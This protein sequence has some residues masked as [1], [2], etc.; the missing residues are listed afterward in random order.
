MKQY[1]KNSLPHDEKLF[2]FDDE[3]QRSYSELDI[4]EKDDKTAAKNLITLND[5]LKPDKQRRPVQLVLI[6]GESGIGKTTLAWQL[7]H[8]WARKELGS[9]KEYDLVVLLPLR[10]KRAQTAEK[11]EN[12]LPCD[13][14]LD[15]R[16]DIMAA[17]GRGKGVLIVCDGFDELPPKQLEE[18]SVYVDLFN[19]DLLSEAT[20][21][22]TTRPS[23]SA[24][25]KRIC[26]RR[27]DRK[28][29]IKGFTETG[30]TEFT[31][32]VFSDDLKLKGFLNYLE[33]NPTIYTLMY[34]PL[35]AII[36]AKIYQEDYETRKKTMSQLFDAFTRVLVRRHILSKHR[37]DVDR[38]TFP[39]TSPANIDKLPHAMAPHFR[40]IAKIAYDGICENMHVF[41]NPEPDKK[42]VT[43]ELMKEDKRHDLHGHYFTYVFFHYILHEYMAAIHIS[44]ML[45]GELDSLQLKLKKEDMITRFLAGICHTNRYE[46]SHKLLQWLIEFLRC[47]CFDRSGALQLVHCAYECFSIMQ[48]LK[49]PYSEKNQFI[50][51]EPKVGIDWYAMGYCIRH[52][53]ERWGLR[54]HATSLRDTDLLKKGLEC[55]LPKSVSGVPPT[56][57]SGRLKY[58]YISKSHL[59]ISQVTTSLGDFGQLHHLDVCVQLDENDKKICVFNGDL[60]ALTSF[61]RSHVTLQVLQLGQIVDYDTSTANH[62]LRELAEVV[63]NRQL[64][65]LKLHKVDYDNL[66]QHLRKSPIIIC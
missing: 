66:P 60:P 21:V 19:G 24:D 6:E 25:F 64:K 54:M 16:K 56:S 22:V 15:N 49:V 29:E 8:Q 38:I 36:I 47:N 10:K 5:I 57:V 7:C 63:V 58:L 39:L 59:P 12:L 51:V 65:K 20:V 1:H 43:L 28:V 46:H 52:F 27:V 35:S 18:D 44:T 48:E 26:N 9:V 32:S 31:K 30:I 33:N 50:V 45:S 4:I 13:K 3:K 55:P 2:Y 53:D 11:A 42:L 62:N 17:I 34:I 14:S 61:V 23:A 40:K 41:K 37:E